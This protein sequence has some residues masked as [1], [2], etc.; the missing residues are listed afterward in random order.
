MVRRRGPCEL[1]ISLVLG[2]PLA[3]S[4]C[5]E[6][7]APVSSTPTADPI[8][9]AK[10]Q[11]CR[12]ISDFNA[13]NQAAVNAHD[14]TKEVSVILQVAPEVQR[15]REGLQSGWRFCDRWS[16]HCLFERPRGN[17]PDCEHGWRPNECGA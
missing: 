3:L 5:G 11:Y 16:T 8:A 13:Q 15:R 6:G 10:A 12:D 17:R 14:P 4:A 1:L 2:L 9:A 7:T